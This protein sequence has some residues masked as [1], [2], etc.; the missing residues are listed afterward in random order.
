MCLYKTN[1]YNNL[2]LVFNL[3]VLYFHAAKYV[4]YYGI[5]LYIEFSFCLKT[6]FHS[7]L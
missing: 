6:G 7:K 2:H 4:V 5:L 3:T 1:T